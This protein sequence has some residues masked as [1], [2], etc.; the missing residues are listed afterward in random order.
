MNFQ[1]DPAVLYYNREEFS[2][3]HEKAIRKN[4]VLPAGWKKKFF[5]RLSHP[6][7]KSS[8]FRKGQVTVELILL[9][10]VLIVL[11]QLVINQIKTNKY[12]EDFAKGPSQ[13]VANM[14]ANGNWKKVLMNQGMSI[15]IFMK[16]IIPGILDMSKKKSSKIWIL[17]SKKTER[18]LVTI[19]FLIAFI[20][21]MFLIL[22]FFRL[23]LTLTY[24][25]VV[26]YI[27]YASARRLSLGDESKDAQKSNGGEK[28]SQLKSKLLKQNTWFDVPDSPQIDFNPDYTESG[29]Q[30]RNLFYGVFVSFTSNLISFRIPLLAEDGDQGLTTTIGSYMGREP[31][32]DECNNFNTE[33]K[34]KI[35]TLIQSN[36]PGI[37]LTI[38]FPVASDNGC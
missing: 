10:V 17:Q 15:P 5:Q 22:S 29:K 26:Q 35:Q 9:G 27:T 2:M 38:S 32:Q 37:S 7:H 3:N 28:Y 20:I 8:S 33:K 12:L 25:S 16:G 30:H 18:G 36:Y 1:P 13:V 14:I 6:S 23:T 19:P 24:A 4:T 11:S 34:Q 31:S 21:V